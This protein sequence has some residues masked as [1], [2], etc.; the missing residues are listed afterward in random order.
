MW[1]FGYGS[2][3]WRPNFKYSALKTGVVKDFARRFYQ[4]SPDHR[5]TEENV[6]FYLIY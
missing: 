5:G 2:L 6:R 4:L 1:I 3:L